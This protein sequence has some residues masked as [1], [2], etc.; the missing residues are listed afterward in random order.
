MR[1]A[2][3]SAVVV[4]GGGYVGL[5]AAAVLSKS[6]KTVTVLEAQSRVLARV[7][8]EPISRFFEQAHRAHGVDV[9]TTVEVAEI[10]GSN[11][12]VTGVLLGSGEMVPAQLVLVG[13]GLLPHQAVMA[14]AGAR[15]GNGVIVDA[16]CRTNLPDIFAI[17]D[18]AAH[19]NPFAEGDHVR[20]ESVQN[21]T[22][23]AKTAAAAILGKAEPYAAV[24]WFWSNQYDLKLQ[25]AGLHYGYDETVLRGD[26][27][28]GRFSLIYL[29]HGRMIA[30][31]CVNSV[32]DFVAGKLLVAR[33]VAAP[34]DILADRNAPLKSLLA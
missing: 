1:V 30:I 16:C 3:A 28:D 12:T 34:R 4:I 2:N 20:I 5:E 26:P 15:S 9:R 18:C 17:G 19:P 32:A 14:Q 21:A 31:D 8:A 11:G 33:R 29:R 27:D 6:G 23:Q 7:A 13:V 10:V 24:P 25:T 22:D